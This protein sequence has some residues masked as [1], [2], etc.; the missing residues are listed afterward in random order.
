MNE[1]GHL[2][3][4]EAG[5]VMVGELENLSSPVGAF[6]RER[7]QVGPGR[8]I[9]RVALFAAWKC[10]CQ[11]QG[12]DHHGDSAAFGRNLRAVVPSLGDTQP[13]TDTGERVRVYEGICLK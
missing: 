3:Q 7:C 11:E 2:V 10:W 4:P 12:R 5:K 8:Q 6:V 13:R 1:R 9:E